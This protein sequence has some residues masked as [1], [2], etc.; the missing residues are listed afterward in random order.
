MELPFSVEPADFAVVGILVL[1][2]GLLSAD[3]ALV[4]A[5]LV[6]HLSQRERAKA[7]LYGLLGAFLFRGIGIFFAARLIDLWWVCAGGAVYLIYLAAAHFVSRVPRGSHEQ[8]SSGPQGPKPA[9][10]FWKT[11][12]LVEITDII[13]A[14]DSI[15]VAVAFVT[16]DSKIWIVYAGGIMGLLL[17]RLAASYFT[18]I[19]ERFPHL[20]AVAYA[21]V[22]WAGVK[23]AST[24]VDI[25][26]KSGGMEALH[27]LPKW[28]FWAGFALIAAIGVPYA[29][30][31]RATN[32]PG[33]VAEKEGTLPS[34][35]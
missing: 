7:L 34:T 19:I 31:R 24:A 30:R 23:L 35:D 9:A 3:N 28:G 25:Y 15:L 10:G 12:F 18:R 27:L 13:F 29:V 32:L 33:A 17:L 6:R 21:L 11:V 2:E 1:L 22:G 20:D 4:L 5:L 14:I 16:D 8:G 26:L